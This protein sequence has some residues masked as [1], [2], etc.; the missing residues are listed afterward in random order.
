MGAAAWVKRN[1]LA[2]PNFKKRLE[3]LYREAL[4]E[5]PKIGYVAHAVLSGQ[6]YADSFEV[7]SVRIDGGRATLA[8]RGTIPFKMD[9]HMV[10][11]RHKDS[12]LADASGDLVRSPPF[13]STLPPLNL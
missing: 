5:D 8:L 2:S 3:D 10:L 4:R 11:I 7:Q 9:L 6:D 13:G 12:W 1:P